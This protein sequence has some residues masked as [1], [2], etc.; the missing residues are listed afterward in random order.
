[1]LIFADKSTTCLGGTIR[2]TRK[3]LKI[4]MS[5]LKEEYTVSALS[6]KGKHVDCEWKGILVFEFSFSTTHAYAKTMK[7]A[8]SL[9]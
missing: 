1:M 9:G 2:A 7:F 6:G 3:V 8:S 5:M 4:K